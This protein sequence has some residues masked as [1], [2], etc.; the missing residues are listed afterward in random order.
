MK[1][2]YYDHETTQQPSFFFVD[3][4]LETADIF[5]GL[6]GESNALDPVETVRVCVR[7]RELLVNDDVS[8]RFGVFL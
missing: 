4:F 7:S 8:I 2:N 1:C 6:S 5:I 3:D